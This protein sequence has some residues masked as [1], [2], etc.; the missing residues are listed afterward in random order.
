[1]KEFIREGREIDARGFVEFSRENQGKISRMEGYRPRVGQ[2]LTQYVGGDS[3]ERFKEK[4]ID[5][6]EEILREHFI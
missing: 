3:V 5:A 6:L 2:F 1:L 4:H